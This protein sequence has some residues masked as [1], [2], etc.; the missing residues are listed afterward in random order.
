M[1]DDYEKSQIIIK[2]CGQAPKDKNKINSATAP[3]YG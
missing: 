1:D 3:K 2:K